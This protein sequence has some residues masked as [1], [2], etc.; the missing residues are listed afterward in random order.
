A[1]LKATEQFAIECAILKVWGSEMLDYVVDEGVQ[2][3]GGMG[4]SAE[5][6]MERAY[7][8]S[9]INRIFEGT[10]EVN[11]LLIVDMLLKRGLKGE[12]DLM[13]PAQAVAGELMAIPDFGDA[14][15][16]PFAYEKKLLANLK[17]A[18]LLVA[19]AAVQK[20]MMTLQQEQE[21]LMKIADIIGEVYLAE[22]D[23]GELDLMGPAQAVAGELMAIPDFGDA[24]NTPFAYEKKLLANLKK[25]GLLVAGAAVQKLMMTL[26]QEQE[27]LMKIADIIGEVYLAE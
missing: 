21:I 27:I 15:N 8:D 24:D 26:Q 7:R 4:Y 18:G 12:L 9:R 10:N 2:I 13:G 20:L 17:K 5:A 19:G 6:P 23:R 3:Y 14:D 1:K 22:S 16:T 25:A 11:R